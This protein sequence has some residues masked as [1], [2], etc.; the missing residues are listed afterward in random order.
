MI[1]DDIDADLL[2]PCGYG[3]YRRY[4]VLNRGSFEELYSRRGSHRLHDWLGQEDG[5]RPRGGRIFRPTF[6]RHRGVIRGGGGSFSHETFRR[7]GPISGELLLGQRVMGGSHSA[8]ELRGPIGLRGLQGGRRGGVHGFRGGLSSESGSN[9]FRRGRLGSHSLEL[10]AWNNHEGFGRGGNLWGRNRRHQNNSHPNNNTTT[11]GNHNHTD[12]RRSPFR[13]EGYLWELILRGRRSLTAEQERDL[14][15]YEEYLGNIIQGPFILTSGDL[16]GVAD[17]FRS[18]QFLWRIIQKE[19]R[20]RIKEEELD[21]FRKEEYLRGLIRREEFVKNREEQRELFLNEEHLRRIIQH[22][23][24][25]LIIEET[26]DLFRYEQYLRHIIRRQRRAHTRRELHVL[27]KVEEYVMNI[28][29]KQRRFLV[30]E[31]QR[32]LYRNEEY[33]VNTVHQARHTLTPQEESDVLRNSAHIRQLIRHERR[34]LY[35][36]EIRDP[37]RRREFA[38]YF[39]GGGH[40]GFRGRRHGRG[41]FRLGQRYPFRSRDFLPYIGG[42]LSAVALVNGAAVAPVAGV[43]NADN[44]QPAVAAGSEEENIVVSSGYT[45]AASGDGYSSYTT[46]APDGGNSV[47]KTIGEVSLKKYILKI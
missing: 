37:C 10:G 35:E 42:G 38:R 39:G 36:L 24:R 46:A 40:H 23:R 5:L 2:D 41:W 32:D 9:E 44:N 43:V 31:E 34:E 22:E 4:S 27:L 1:D 47:E 30:K 19:R 14:F 21:I 6:F 16:P 18:E 29:Q 45:T 25:E 26:E 33:L 12:S 17:P 3:G 11:E 28:I 8:E 7:R 13:D 20:A 15:R